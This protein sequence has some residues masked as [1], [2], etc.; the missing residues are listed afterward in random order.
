[1]LLFL[2]TDINECHFNKGNCRH[3]CYNT[4]GSYYCECNTGY[5]LHSDNHRCKGTYV[6]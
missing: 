3:N 4:V 2:I 6:W 5:K 1:M